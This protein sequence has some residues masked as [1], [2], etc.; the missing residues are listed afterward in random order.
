MAN[1]GS[2]NDQFK[3]KIDNF[4]PSFKIFIFDDYSQHVRKPQDSKSVFINTVP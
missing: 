3:L 1:F 2:K 4:G